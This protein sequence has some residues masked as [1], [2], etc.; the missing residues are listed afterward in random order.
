MAEVTESMLVVL[1]VIKRIGPILLCDNHNSANPVH[2]VKWRP[3]CRAVKQ[4]FQALHL[5]V[6]LARPFHEPLE[7]PAARCWKDR[8]RWRERVPIAVMTAPMCVKN[9]VLLVL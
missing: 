8:R 6:L 3:R 1:V 2:L 7:R 9:R 5:D 4:R